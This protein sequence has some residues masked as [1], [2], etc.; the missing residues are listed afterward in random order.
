MTS[1]TQMTKISRSAR[2]KSD[3]YSYD[4]V[5]TPMISSI[6]TTCSNGN[7]S[8]DTRAGGSE[9]TGSRK[10]SVKMRVG[11]EVDEGEDE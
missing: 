11:A 8:R 5:S 1:V 9:G 3:R 7:S 6:S 4:T 2:E 10:D